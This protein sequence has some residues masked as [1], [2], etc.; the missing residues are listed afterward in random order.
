M[1][2]AIFRIPQK[3]IKDLKERAERIAARLK[4]KTKVDIKREQEHFCRQALDHLDKFNR[5]DILPEKA[6]HKVQAEQALKKCLEI[7]RGNH[8]FRTQLKYCQE[9]SL[10][11]RYA[12]IEII[13]SRDR[14]R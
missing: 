14:Y 2:K 7:R 12:Q 5:I 1:L 8:L 10:E 13:L 9:A 3:R 4:R 11:D 6:I